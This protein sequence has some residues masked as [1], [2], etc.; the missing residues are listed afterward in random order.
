M[1][2]V[3]ELKDLIEGFTQDIELEYNGAPGRH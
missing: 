1:K 3:D 2:S